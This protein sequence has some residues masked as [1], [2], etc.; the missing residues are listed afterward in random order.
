MSKKRKRKNQISLSRND[1]FSIVIIIMTACSILIGVKTLNYTEL[2]TRGDRI[3]QN[4]MIIEGIESCKEN[5]D[6]K[7]SNLYHLDGRRATCEE[8]L[9][10]YN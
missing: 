1:K 10:V 5:L 3:D 9:K 2:A 4:A 6:L 8:V 7:E